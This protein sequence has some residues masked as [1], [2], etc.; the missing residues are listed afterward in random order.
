MVANV[1]GF[2]YEI[3]VGDLVWQ[4]RQPGGWCIVLDVTEWDEENPSP[5]GWLRADHPIYK[6]A[7]PTEGIIQDAS[8][9]Y[10]TVDEHEELINRV[11]KDGR[12]IGYKDGFEPSKFFDQRSDD[13][14]S[15]S[16]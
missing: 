2:L 8:Y 11:W 15:E 16:G 5:Q 3:K 10:H 14:E 4:S 1:Q 12:I 13:N 7:H 6:V 9:Y